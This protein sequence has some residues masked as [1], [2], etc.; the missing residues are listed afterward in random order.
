MTVFANDTFAVNANMSAPDK[1]GS[2]LDIGLQNFDF[3]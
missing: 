1:A 3:P 2:F